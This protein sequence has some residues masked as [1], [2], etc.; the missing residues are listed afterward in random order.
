MKRCVKSAVIRDNQAKIKMRYYFIHNR[1]AKTKPKQNK[2]SEIRKIAGG[3]E[4]EENGTPDAV[5]VG[6]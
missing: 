3:I 6:M 5:M 1:V 4:E 2:N